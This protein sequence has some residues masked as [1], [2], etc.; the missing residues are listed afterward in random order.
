MPQVALLCCSKATTQQRRAS[1]YGFAPPGFFCGSPASWLLHKVLRQAG[2]R[3][4]GP[5]TGVTCGRLC[6]RT[7]KN[8]RKRV[9][10]HSGGVYGFFDEVEKTIHPTPKGSVGEPGSRTLPQVNPIEGHGPQYLSIKP[11]LQQVAT[12]ATSRCY[13]ISS[14]ALQSG[15]RKS[16]HMW[17]TS[18]PLRAKKPLHVLAS[19]PIVLYDSIEPTSSSERKTTR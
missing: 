12:A 2:L 17:A 4:T 1:I 6:L 14:T 16:L 18:P 11:G 13:G 9:P 10:A 3:G 19:P 5:S 7:A 8:A 15:R